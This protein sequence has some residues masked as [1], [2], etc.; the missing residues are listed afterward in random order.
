MEEAYRNLGIDPDEASGMNHRF[1]GTA[2]RRDPDYVPSEHEVQNEVQNEVQTVVEHAAEIPEEQVE[3]ILTQVMP[4]LKKS[5]FCESTL[6]TR[7]W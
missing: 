4:L 7:E 6:N 2:H 3:N 1:M 5:P